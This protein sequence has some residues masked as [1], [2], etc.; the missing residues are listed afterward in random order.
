MNPAPRP[1]SPESRDAMQ[2]ANRRENP[3]QLSSRDARILMGL[4]GANGGNGATFSRPE[5][6]ERAERERI[7]SFFSEN[8]LNPAEAYPN[9]GYSQTPTP[10]RP[11]R[12]Q[13][14]EPP[15]RGPPNHMVSFAL[16]PSIVLLV[17]L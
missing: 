7:N 5:R 6:A 3:H 2:R 12:Q 15:V 17:I 4:P 11:V 16:S 9:E 8:G 10:V 1:P 14:T 13:R